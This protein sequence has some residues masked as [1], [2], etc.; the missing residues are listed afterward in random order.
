MKDWIAELF[1]DPEL[2]R[3]GH[4]QRV[5]D[6]NLGLGWLYYGLAR[7]LRP[8]VVVVIGSYRGFV[9][10]VLGKALV[11]NGSG[12]R[13]HFIDPS[14]VDGFWRDAAAV[15]AHFAR[16]G[17]SNIR[18]YLMTTQ[19]FVESAA[20]RELDSPGIV[21]IDGYHTEEQARFDFESFQGRLAGDGVTLFHD[22]RYVKPSRMYGADR[23]YTRKV[24]CFIDTLKQDPS[25][26]VFDLPFGDGVT[27]VRR[28]ADSA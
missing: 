23:V 27:L 11:D 22:S 10:M 24:K 26:Q 15:N 28:A 25:L 8:E 17:L 12:G 14:Y 4:A 7:V 20:Y 1:R 2:T 13:V 9:P 6:L 19:Q 16:Y 3:M 18:H 21:F 5:E